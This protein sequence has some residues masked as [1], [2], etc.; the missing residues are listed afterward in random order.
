[1]TAW[2]FGA[3]AAL[4]GGIL[5][6]GLVAPRS[7]WRVLV[8]WSARDPAAAE[9]GDS[10]HGVRRFICAFGLA[11]LAAVLGVQL[12]NGLAT[13][14]SAAA[15]PDPVERMWG[16]PPPRLVDR[17]VVPLAEPPAHLLAGPIPGYQAIEP[18]F[19]PHYLV[20]LPKFALLGDTAPLG[21][22]GTYPG[23]G[24]T[25]YGVADLL[26]ATQG[27]LLCVPRAAVVVETETEVQ[28]GVYWG[29]AGDDAQ[30]HLA[31]CTIAEGDLLQTVL[32]PLGLA[33]ELGARSVV[34][35]EGQPVGEVPVID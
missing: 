14:P 1:M 18:G 10:V 28:V 20:D 22:L 13:Q 31:A 34:T 2:V 12:W 26:V 16:S 4:L 24:Y 9:P 19:A 35:V 6:W 8:G 3:L 17:T 21:L 29:L 27:P 33:S 32:V 5:L 23:D 15:E 25:A 7:Q 30:D 11:G